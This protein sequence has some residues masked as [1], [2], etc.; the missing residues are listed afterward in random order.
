VNF[1]PAGQ[2]VD[3]INFSVDFDETCLTFTDAAGA[4]VFNV[5]ASFTTSYTYA[6]GDK[7]GEIDFSIYPTGSPSPAIAAGQIATI[8]LGVKG[9]CQ[10]A[11]G[12]VRTARVG[13]SRDPKA[14]FG[15][16]G[17]SISARTSD[18]SISIS[19]AT[20]A[21]DCN[22]DG[23][24]DAGDISG[25]V[26]EIFDA[27]GNLPANVPLST[28]AGSPVGCNPNNDTIIDAGDV[29]CMAK[30]MFGTACSGGTASLAASF[31]LNPL[32]NLSGPSALLQGVA[33]KVPVQYTGNG[34]SVN[35]LIF[36]VRYDPDTMYF[37]PADAD[38]D[39]IPD[40]LNLSL[41]AGFQAF[42]SLA[43]P[44][45][46]GVVVV[47]LSDPDAVL[48]DGSLGEVTFLVPR[49]A[50][51]GKTEISFGEDPAVSFGGGGLSVPG[52]SE[53]YLASI[54]NTLWVYMPAVRR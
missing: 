8:K 14:S 46:I 43:T 42:V 36:S 9:T 47:N 23:I 11:P 30:L 44:S 53:T 40:A 49:D 33:Y 39:G 51:P 41:P 54:L 18:G 5:G 21:G 50:Q 25:L 32:I 20:M 45:Q 24:R 27:D 37:D 29:S 28:F 17:A 1:T 16:N 7:D 31:T 6:A 19:P 22:G 3:A 4:V 38:E 35:S 13:F 52:D 10:A 12:T 15:R 2:E 48:A 26:N 34:S